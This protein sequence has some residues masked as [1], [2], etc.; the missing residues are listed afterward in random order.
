MTPWWGLSAPASHPGV[1]PDPEV[2]PLAFTSD[3]LG[4]PL[5]V[6]HTVR[7]PLL[8]STLGMAECWV[9]AALLSIRKQQYTQKYANIQGCTNMYKYSNTSLW[10]VGLILRHNQGATWLTQTKQMQSRDEPHGP[11]QKAPA[12]PQPWT[13]HVAPGAAPGL[14]AQ[15]Y[16]AGNTDMQIEQDCVASLWSLCQ[17][18][19]H[20][21]KTMI[22][23]R[24]REVVKRIKAIKKCGAN[25]SGTGNQFQTHSQQKLLI[26]KLNWLCLTLSILLAYRKISDV[27]CFCEPGGS[28][29]IFPG[30]SEDEFLKR[31]SRTLWS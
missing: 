3:W 31:N 5:E 6:S 29:E 12:W 1:L 23:I 9:S 14:P 28:M 18:V 4:L 8:V 20:S 11:A 30:R 19:D 25:N 2:P 16:D 17:N 22:I 15:F 13:S 26:L 27:N 21:L 7:S 10:N 24:H